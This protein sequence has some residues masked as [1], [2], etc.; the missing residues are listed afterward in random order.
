MMIP[1]DQR[2]A[3]MEDPEQHF[4]WALSNFPVREDGT[5]MVLPIM[6]LPIV[7]RHLWDCGFRHHP[8]LQ[9][10]RQQA[11]PS[12]ALEQAGV[13]WVLTD[14]GAPDP[15]P[16]VDLANLSDAEAAAVQAALDRRKAAGK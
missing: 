12:V 10:I 14:D 16:T 2:K 11:D 3:D 1:I 4:G 5:P 7:S 9:T 15:L 13:R 6:C 8:D